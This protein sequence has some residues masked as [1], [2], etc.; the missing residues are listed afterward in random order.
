[1]MI[2]LY[3]DDTTRHEPQVYITLFDW[4]GVESI[5][6]LSEL[7][8]THIVSKLADAS[9]NGKSQSSYYINALSMRARF[10]SQ[11]HAEVW[12]FKSNL[13]MESLREFADDHPQEYADWMR[14]NG[15]C[16]YGGDKPAGE[17]KIR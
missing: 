10:N 3:D 7:E 14:K 17:Q 15:V 13:E 1:M 16:I 12:G 6:N 11:R 5:I 9:Y 4:H 2:D 8:E